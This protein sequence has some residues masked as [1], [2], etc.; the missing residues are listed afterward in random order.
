MSTPLRLSDLSSARQALVRLCQEMNYGSIEN[1][2][3][4]DCEPMFNPPPTVVWDVK[5]DSEESARPE[6]ALP[7]FIV[8]KEILRLIRHLDEIKLG[9]FR[10]VEVRA[11]IPR[12][13]LMESRRSGSAEPPTKY[14]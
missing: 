13:I 14:R 1:L 10:R 2:E 4:R 9:K 5:L 12:R 3:I 11:G 6:T 7:D 8:S